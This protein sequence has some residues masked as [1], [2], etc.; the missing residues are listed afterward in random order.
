MGVDEEFDRRV[1]TIH[2]LEHMSPLSTKR[3]APPTDV[4]HAEFEAMTDVFLG[5][6]YDRE[7]LEKVERLQVSLLDQQADLFLLHQNGKITSAMCVESLNGA[8]NDVF[9]KIEGVLGPDG[10]LKLFGVQR[11]E[12][13]RWFDE[14]SFRLE[15]DRGTQRYPEGSTNA[16]QRAPQQSV[17]PEVVVDESQAHAAYANFARITATADE[18]I[19]DFGLNPNPFA[20]GRTAVSISQRLVLNFYTAKRLLGALQTTIQ[21]HEAAF[22]VMEIDVRR[23]AN[24]AT[25]PARAAAEQRENAVTGSR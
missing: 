17:Q 1:A 24:L 13:A 5:P 12:T 9:A 3:S 2:G 15:H 19:V 10:F 4:R 8:T 6:D 18:V 23:R 14:E 22:G 16:S 7:K 11:H 25:L 21:R 20:I